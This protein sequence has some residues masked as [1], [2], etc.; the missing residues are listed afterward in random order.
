MTLGWIGWSALV[1]GAYAGFLLG[2]VIGGLLALA[3][4]V[5]RRGYPFGPFMLAGAWL[6]AVT[7]PLT[8]GWV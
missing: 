1:V 3:K 7:S 8:A 4:V 5:D 6:G 2:A